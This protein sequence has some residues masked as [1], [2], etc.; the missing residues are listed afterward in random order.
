[1]T[2]R[3]RCV[4]A[5][6]L[7][8]A[9]AGW[10]SSE[11]ASAKDRPLEPGV[12]LQTILEFEATARLLAILLDSG[13]N[14]INEHQV[15]FDEQE[16]TEKDFT[17]DLF[18]RQ[19]V[20]VFR[21]RSGVDLQDLESARIPLRAKRLLKELV[22]V[23]KQVVAEA[24]A[25]INRPSGELKEFIPAV[26]GARVA[27]RFTERT[28]VRLKQT[29]LAPRNPLNAP[30]SVERT[31]L[32]AFADPSYPLEKVI[33]EVTAKKKSLHLMFPLYT[34]RKCLDCHGDPKGELDRTGYPREG[35]R[36]G[37]NAGAISVVMPIRP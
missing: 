17:A 10:T 20:D 15:P 36:L 8:C 16:K 9:M 6:L 22:R 2:S 31:A 24:Q 19:L 18:E 29:A 32:E 37:Q 3:L 23:S 25:Q 13:R 4:I 12:P 21:S 26:F 33:S 27:S 30:D 7:A 14:V 11:G 1:M 5:S 28:H 34:T 35:L